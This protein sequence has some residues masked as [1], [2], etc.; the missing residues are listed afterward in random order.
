MGPSLRAGAASLCQRLCAHAGIARSADELGTLSKEVEA[1]KAGQAALQKDL[2]EIK[3]LLQGAASGD[4]TCAG[5]STG[6]GAEP[7]D[8]VVSLAGAPVKGENNA[9]VTLVEF[10]DYQCPFCSRHYR[11]TWP[12]LEQEYIKT[13]K[14][15]LV[16]RDMPL[17]A[18]HPQALKAAEAAHCAGEQ[19]KY[20]EM[21]DRLFA[22]QNAL[23]RK[24]LSD[25]AQA[26]GLDVPRSTNA[27]TAASQR[28]GCARIWSMRTRRGRR[29]RRPFSSASPSPNS[30]ELKALRV[31]RGA[32]PYA[33]FKEAIDGVLAAAN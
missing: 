9:K 17:E 14:V 28:R 7:T 32:Q 12:Q 8:V 2:Q 1:L 10:T 23:A 25:S 5:G 27:S 4:S 19:G 24:D 30:S 15:K 18:I 29:G 21:H 13:G 11:Q 26:L 33:A 20:W 3:S 6:P 31:L 22:N 16:L